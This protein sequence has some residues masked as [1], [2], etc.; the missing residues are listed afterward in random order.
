MYVI[1]K[2]SFIFAFIPRAAS[3]MGITGRWDE[4]RGDCF[5]FL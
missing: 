1:N 4:I 3:L 5:V 2:S